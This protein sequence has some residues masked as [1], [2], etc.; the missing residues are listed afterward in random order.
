MKVNFVLTKAE[1]FCFIFNTEICKMLGIFI[2]VELLSFVVLKFLGED[3]YTDS[4]WVLKKIQEFYSA[5]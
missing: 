3:I 2:S 1:Y 5:L 4:V